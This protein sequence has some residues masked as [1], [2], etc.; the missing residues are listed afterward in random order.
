M[1]TFEFQGGFWCWSWNNLVF[2]SD[3]RQLFESLRIASSLETL[4][5]PYLYVKALRQRP[6]FSTILIERS[7]V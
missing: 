1:R 2:E 7:H 4:V 3:I 6:I 5:S